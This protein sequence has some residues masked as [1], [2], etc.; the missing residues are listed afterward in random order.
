MQTTSRRPVPLSRPSWEQIATGAAVIAIAAALIVLPPLYSAILLAGAALATVIVVRPLWGFYLLLLSIPAQDLGAVGELTATNVLFVLTVIAWLAHRLAFGGKPLPRS[1]IGP[2]FA[3]F[4]GGLALS[5]TVARDLAPAI[6]GLFQWVKSLVI[7]FLALDFLRTRRQTLTALAILLVAGAAEGAIGLFQYLTGVGPASFTVGD[8]FSRAF[9]TFGRPNS[10]AGYL[11]MIFPLGLAASYL[12]LNRRNLGLGRS[13]G[14][15]LRIIAACSAT[16]LIGAALFASYSRGAWLGTVGALAVMILLYGARARVAVVVGVMLLALILLAGG[17]NYLPPGFADRL[18]NAFGN[19]ETPDVRTAFITAENF[20]TV[21][22]RA[23]WEAG[24]QMFAD[25]RLLGVGLGNF[26]LRF[27]EYTVSPTFLVSQGH[28]HNYY[29]HVAAEAGIV[30]L[31][32]YL[33]LLATIVFTGLR[34]LWLT[35]RPGADPVARIIVIAALAVI[36][37]VVIHNVVENLHVLSMGVQLSTV[38][39]LLAIVTQPSWSM[40]QTAATEAE[41][42]EDR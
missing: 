4:V 18:L 31:L 10:Y 3:L 5:L 39:A 30:G 34:A 40:P 2:V 19:V 11:E 13:R 12:V 28:A 32:G 42:R 14:G 1:A 37:A 16:G 29:I 24:L 20:S 41:T 36:A 21:E 8:Q 38:W 33:L 7:F 9:G 15:R 6:A 22:R 26:N 27:P 25:N 35:S 17:A 23:H